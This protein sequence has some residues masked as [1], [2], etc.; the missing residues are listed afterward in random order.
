MLLGQ[1]GERGEKVPEVKKLTRFL[2]GS[3]FMYERNNDIKT[4][5]LV[6]VITY[7]LFGDEETPGDEPIPD[8]A[9]VS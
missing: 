7:L 1:L 3:L 5:Y 8:A 4:V 6:K 9:A 2:W